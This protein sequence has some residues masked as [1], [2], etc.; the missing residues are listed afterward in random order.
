MGGEDGAYDRN[1]IAARWGETLD[2]LDEV[3][4]GDTAFRMHLVGVAHRRVLAS[5]TAWQPG[6]AIP[7]SLR[8]PLGELTDLERDVVLAQVCAGLSMSE[9]A[10]ALGQSRASVTVAQR[11]AL[12]RLEETYVDN[13]SRAHK[14]RR[15]V[16][17]DE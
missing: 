7:V 12:L 10:A 5:G 8:G 1:K 6:P 15:Q 13:L 14:L 17:I 9:V 11:R 4:G 3:L 2:A 16:E